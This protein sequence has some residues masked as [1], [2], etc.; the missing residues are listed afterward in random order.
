MIPMQTLRP[1]SPSN[2]DAFSPT[3]TQESMDLARQQLKQL[4]AAGSN[5]VE[6]KLGLNSAAQIVLD[7]IK[8]AQRAK[9]HRKDCTYIADQAYQLV[10][11]VDGGVKGRAIDVNDILREHILHLN[12]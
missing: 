6:T 11:A 9:S 7:I 2:F 3:P 4:V 5:K 8:F 10:N 1:D 12:E